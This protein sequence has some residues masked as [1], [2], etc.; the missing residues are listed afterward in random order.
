MLLGDAV[1]I[2]SAEQDFPARHHHHA[3]LWKQCLQNGLG[4]GVLGVIKLRRNDAAVDDQ[5]VDVG[6]GQANRGIT[7]DRKSVV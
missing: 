1:D 4:F 5:E 3:V 7:L 2:A 6:T